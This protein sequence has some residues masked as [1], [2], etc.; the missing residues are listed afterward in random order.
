MSS[1]STSQ[2]VP[3]ITWLDS[4]SQLIASIG[5]GTK[6][7]SATMMNPNGGYFSTLSFN[8][9]LASDAGLY[10]C[11]VIVGSIIMVETVTINIS[12]MFIPKGL[13]LHVFHTVFCIT[14]PVVQ[15]SDGGRDPMTGKNYT[16]MCNVM[17]NINLTYTYQ[18]RRNGAL[19]PQMGPILLFSSLQLS[20]AGRYMCETIGDINV[21]SDI[22][23]VTLQG[24]SYNNHKIHGP[25][26]I[27][28]ITNSLCSSHS[29]SVRDW[30]RFSDSIQWNNL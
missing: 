21:M 2:V 22:F 18:W 5:D 26:T 25:W 6:A 3:T 17:G 4:N 12:G 29:S 20:D 23:N 24:K 16:L 15:I 28:H 27:N 9:L 10:M 30:P 11:R 13:R 8:P 1:G 7:I 14:D 19:L